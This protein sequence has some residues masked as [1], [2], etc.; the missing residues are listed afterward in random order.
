MVRKYT[1]SLSVQNICSSSGLSLGSR[2]FQISVPV[3][4][5]NPANFEFESRSQSRILLWVP[6]PVLIS[7]TGP[8]GSRGPCLRC[9]PLFW[10]TNS[11]TCHSQN[12][13]ETSVSQ[14]YPSNK[15]W[16]SHFAS[17][18]SFVD[19]AKNNNS[20]KSSK[21]WVHWIWG[22]SWHNLSLKTDLWNSHISGFI[23]SKS[24]LYHSGSY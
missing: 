16:S 17:K 2:I 9:R 20:L 22:I 23:Q 14:N 6:V 1:V 18:S 15:K 19:Y 11:R 21:S 7:E 24:Y 13:L 5:P 10:T 12:R 8:A 4:V 3:P